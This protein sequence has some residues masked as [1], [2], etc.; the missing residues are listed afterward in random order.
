MPAGNSVYQPTT[1]SY[2]PRA[3]S[4]LGQ[5]TASSPLQV[6]RKPV[7]QMIMLTLGLLTIALGNVPVHIYQPIECI[8]IYYERIHL[9]GT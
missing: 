6:L 9:T 2:E 3:G 8:A 4:L 1:V 5:T 7:P